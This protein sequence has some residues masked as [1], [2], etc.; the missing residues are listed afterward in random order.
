MF[1]RSIIGSESH[2][3]VVAFPPLPCHLA[4]SELLILCQLH[5]LYVGHHTSMGNGDGSDNSPFT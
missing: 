2:E 5:L 4:C 3:L 1:S